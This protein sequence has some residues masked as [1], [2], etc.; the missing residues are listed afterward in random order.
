[1][2]ELGIWP[3][4]SAAGLISTSRG[5]TLSLAEQPGLTSVSAVDLR[6]S[7]LCWLAKS[8][9]HEFLTLSFNTVHWHSTSCSLSLTFYPPA[10]LNACVAAVSGV[11][12]WLCHW[13]PPTNST[14][15][16]KASVGR[17]AMRK[18]QP[19]SPSNPAAFCCSRS[20]RHSDTHTAI[21][22]KW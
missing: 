10:C 1:M 9:V 2:N 3:C 16:L 6:A 4:L 17:E 15:E 11:W 20:E 12:W 13:A 18:T 19:P 7:S 5:Q 8:L 22:F 21:T 14:T